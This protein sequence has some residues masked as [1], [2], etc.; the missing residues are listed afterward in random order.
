MMQ[1]KL[2]FVYSHN[3]Y[4]E[5]LVPKD[6]TKVEVISTLLTTHIESLI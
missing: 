5:G 3:F 1:E 4:R 6:Q 2:V